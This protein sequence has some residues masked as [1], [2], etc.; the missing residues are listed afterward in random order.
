MI[1]ADSH[2]IEPPE[3]YTERM[4]RWG[5]RA[6]HV[7]RDADGN[8]WWYVDG[9]RTNSFAGG[10]Q[11]GRR[12]DDPG[13]LVLADRFDNVRTAA[14]DPE[15]Y[16]DENLT[17]GVEGSVLYPT[18][19]M[20]HY[21]VRNR[22]L[23]DDACRAYNSWL[24]EF[25]AA[26]PDRLRGLAALNVDDPAT[27]AAELARA[28][29]LGLAGALIPV[30]LPT[31]DTYADRKFDILWAAAVDHDCPLSLH[32]GTYRANPARAK[33]PVIPGA[34][35]ASPKPAQTAFATADHWIRQS[36]A[37]LIYS[38]VFERHPALAVV[39]A[40]HEIGWLAF[41]AERLDY[42]YTQRA[43]KGLRFGDQRLPSDFLRTNVWVQFCEDPLVCSAIEA[44]GP[45]RVLWGS[46]YPHSEG[47]FPHSQRV[48]A[49]RLGAL[50]ASER[51]RITATNARGL[52]W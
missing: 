32:I 28:R 8:D 14:Y 44:V 46:D 10:S 49:D 18:Q 52:Y 9:H 6:P 40:E 4:A 43:T 37:D 50:D 35:L 39:S 34:Q 23:V 25:C 11:T 20:Q 12:F 38:G 2:V 13:A 5:D 51:E 21:A 3:L 22:E 15:R 1:S 42:T 17:D 19:Q 47:L 24:A 45:D 27:A 48:V 41:F 16:A 26:R 33:A 36:L 31:G 29:R 30:G 7:V